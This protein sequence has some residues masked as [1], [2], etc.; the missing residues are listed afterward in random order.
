MPVQVKSIWKEFGTRVR[1]RHWSTN[2]RVEFTTCPR[3][4]VSDLHKQ[5]ALLCVYDLNSM[6][7]PLR[8][9]QKCNIPEFFLF[10]II[11]WLI[12][13]LLVSRSGLVEEYAV[14]VFHYY[15]NQNWN[16][17]YFQVSPSSHFVRSCRPF[18]FLTTYS[19]CR[20]FFWCPVW[21]TT[22]AIIII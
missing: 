7:T 4:P 14:E 6:F 13:M 21:S 17:L 11:D 8:F 16:Y 3:V 18:V 15:K 9:C 5:P 12:D 20:S 10:S 1:R 2:C 19:E 22:Q